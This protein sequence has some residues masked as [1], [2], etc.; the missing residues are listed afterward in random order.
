[1]SYQSL[2]KLREHEAGVENPWPEASGGRVTEFLPDDVK[3]H[4]VHARALSLARIGVCQV[5][6]EEVTEEDTVEVRSAIIHGVAFYLYR[7]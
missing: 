5:N 1:M 2:F 3:M 7:A 6:N 4:Y